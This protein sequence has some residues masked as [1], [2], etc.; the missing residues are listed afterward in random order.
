V[1]KLHNKFELDFSERFRS[2]KEKVKNGLIIENKHRDASYEISDDRSIEQGH[3]DHILVCGE[4]PWWISVYL[5][6]V[7]DVLV[8]GWIMRLYLNSSARKVEFTLKKR[9][10]Y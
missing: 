8:L 7:L 4:K 6:V 10:A 9:I 3:L 2:M 1:V 5:L